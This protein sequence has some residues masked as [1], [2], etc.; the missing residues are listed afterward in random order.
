MT[1]YHVLDYNF[2]HVGWVR[3]LNVEAALQAAKAKFPQAVAPM[4]FE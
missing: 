3:A 2:Q 4:V 1:E